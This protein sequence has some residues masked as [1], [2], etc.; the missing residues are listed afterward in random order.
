MARPKEFSREEVL[1]KAMITFWRLGYEATSVQDLVAAMGINRGSLYDTFGD[2][3]DLFLATL[4]H[5]IQSVVK[6]TFSRLEKS[7]SVKQA[8]TEFILDFFVEPAIT[9]LDLKGCLVTNS[10]VEL[11][12][13]DQECARR[14]LKNLQWIEE[15]F[16][17][18]LVRAQ[19]QGEISEEKDLRALSRFFTSGLQG[20]QVMAKLDP[21]RTKLRDIAQ[22]MVSVLS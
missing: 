21:D 22:V 7:G 14:V 3:H 6:V 4:D 17:R 15:T 10:V 20:L 5:Y 16:Y 8:L 2:K 12:P 18:V 9:D 19:E 11:A 1:N 13:H